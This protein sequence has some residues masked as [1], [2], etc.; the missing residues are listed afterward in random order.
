MRRLTEQT[1]EDIKRAFLSWENTGISQEHLIKQLA[2]H[3]IGL[4]QIA[5]EQADWFEPE[6][7]DGHDGG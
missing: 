6:V 2:N 3:A 1:K 4:L 7:S 5:D